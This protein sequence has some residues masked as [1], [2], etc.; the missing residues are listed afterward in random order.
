MKDVFDI[1][2]DYLD[3]NGLDGLRNLEVG[4]ACIVKSVSYCGDIKDSCLPGRKIPCDPNICN[5]P[6]GPHILP[7]RRSRE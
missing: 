1:V 7:G 2:V 5:V 4:C 6:C 3:N